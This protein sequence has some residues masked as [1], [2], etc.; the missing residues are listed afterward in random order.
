VWMDTQGDGAAGSTYYKLEFTNLSRTTCSLVGYPGVSALNLMGRQVGSAA[1]RNSAQAVRTVAL[2]SGATAS[3][4]LQITDVANFPAVTCR[5]LTVAG[6]R[7][8]PPNQGTPKGGPLPFRACSRDG[9]VY[10]SR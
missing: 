7:V 6:I 8:Y 9:S 3:A 4:V 1:S 2:S 5:P 10:P